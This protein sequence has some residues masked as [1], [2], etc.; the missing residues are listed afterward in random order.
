MQNQTYDEEYYVEKILAKRDY[1]EVRYLIKWDGWDIKDSTWEP[2]ENLWNAMELV[3]EFEKREAIKKHDK[4]FKKEALIQ[5]S[6]QSV[7]NKY[8]EYEEATPPRQ[9]TISNFKEKEEQKSF[10]EYRSSKIKK[11]KE[12]EK[13]DNVLM[14]FPNE[15][16]AESI[17]TVKLIKDA[18]HCL[19]SFK[20]RSNGIKSDDAFVPS[21]VLADRIPNML[22][23]FYESKIKFI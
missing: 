12:K 22:I 6:K 23:D 21:A 7:Y 11:E 10:K 1:P 3:D 8:I 5:K 19:V 15:E 20:P 4:T 2:I 13:K 18:I 9:K 17:K 14:R 16:E